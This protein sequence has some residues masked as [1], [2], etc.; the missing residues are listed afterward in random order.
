MGK[1]KILI[2]DDQQLIL[3]PLNKWLTNLGYEVSCA[4]NVFDAIAAYDTFSPDLVITDINMPML[5]GGNGLT[6]PTD[7]NEKAAGLEIVKYIRFIKQSPSPIIVLSGNVEENIIKRGFELGVNEY[8]KKPLILK[9]IG[10]R[11]QRLLSADRFSW[12][13]KA[14]LAF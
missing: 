3:L 1:T 11:V 12:K 7:I 10:I 6:S 5:P 4:E 14:G 2:V 9:E 8:M 13:T